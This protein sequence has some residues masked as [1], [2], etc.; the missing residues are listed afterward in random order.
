MHCKSPRMKRN[1]FA[2]RRAILILLLCLMPISLLAQKVNPDT[3]NLE[4]LSL[5]KHKAVIMRNTGMII[6][7]GGIGMAGAGMLFAYE[8]GYGDLSYLDENGAIS[9]A[10]ISGVVG[11]A[12]ILVGVPLWATGGSR[13]AKA[14]LSLQ[15]Y[16]LAPEGSMALGLGITITF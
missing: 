10:V 8:N 5:Y 4:Q 13:K 3:L 7:C 6:T 2:I 11:I 9:L 14:E 12:S 15:K 1:S 16:N